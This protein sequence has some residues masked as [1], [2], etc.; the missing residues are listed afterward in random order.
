[1]EE[2]SKYGVVVFNEESGQIADFVEKPQ[3]Y[4]GNKINA[5]LYIFNPAVLD[6]IELRP[7]SIEKEVFPQ[8]ASSGNLFA[9]VLP[10][11]WMDVGQPRDFLKGT[12]LYLRHCQSTRDGALASGADVSGNV[13]IDSTAN[14]GKNCK[15]GP[16]VVN[17][18]S[19]SFKKR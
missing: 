3:E 9:F 13:L 5:G 18:L 14:I 7:T 8:M 10:G 4:V 2:P 11:F 12:A 16:N 17:I 19:Y 6:R 15:I 1:M